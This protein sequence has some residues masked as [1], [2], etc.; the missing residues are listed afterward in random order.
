[1]LTHRVR[2]RSPLQH[3][4]NCP[5]CE[6]RDTKLSPDRAQRGARQRLGTHFPCA[7][8]P[9]LACEGSGSWDQRPRTLR[10]RA[11]R[12]AVKSL[13]VASQPRAIERVATATRELPVLHGRRWMVEVASHVAAMAESILEV[14]AMQEVFVGADFTALCVLTLR[15]NYWDL[16][17]RPQRCRERVLEVVLRRRWDAVPQRVRRPST[18][19]AILLG[20]RL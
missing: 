4:D 17:E 5:Q 6:Q 14:H 20:G 18:D 19:E 3:R 12:E 2:E 1:V 7:R 8:D 15:F 16:T 9:L 13:E 11:K 10:C